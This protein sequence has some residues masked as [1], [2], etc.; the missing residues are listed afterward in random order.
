MWG[1]HFHLW[2]KKHLTFSRSN[3]HNTFNMVVPLS[4]LSTDAFTQ[5]CT[6]STVS[7]LGIGGCSHLSMLLRGCIS[8][9]T[10]CKVCMRTNE[11]WLHSLEI[12]MRK[13]QVV[14]LTILREEPSNESRSYTLQHSLNLFHK[15]TY[16]DTTC[17]W[18]R[19]CLSWYKQQNKRK[20]YKTL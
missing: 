1:I 13:S 8:C 20:Q 4:E 11:Q 10:W 15:K 7:V 9:A 5:N 19:K 2:L 3:M 18:T 6:G 17:K 14:S 12:T 16:I